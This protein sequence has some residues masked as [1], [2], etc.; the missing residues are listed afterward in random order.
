MGVICTGAS[1]YQVNASKLRRL[2][3][4]V[5]LEELPDSRERT[6]APV[7]WLSCDGQKDVWV[8]FS[9]NSYLSA[10]IDRQG[11]LFPASVDLRTNNTECF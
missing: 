8:L 3:D 11:L 5:D 6:R 10:I 9:D 2:L 4:A 1:I 7:L